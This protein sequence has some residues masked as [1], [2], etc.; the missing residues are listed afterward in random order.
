MRRVACRSWPRRAASLIEVMVV[1]TMMG[2]LVAMSAP[3]YRRAVEQAR[4]D[5]A[6][7]NLKAVWSAQ[8]LYWLEHGT[9]ATTLTQLD[10]LLDPAVTASTTFYVYSISSAGTSTF[11]AAATRTGS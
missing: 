4:A 6:A 3:T 7:A 2:V 1:L 11:S 8:R 10:S 5:I 9:F